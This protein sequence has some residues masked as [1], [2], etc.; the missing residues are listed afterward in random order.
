[1]VGAH[2]K[3]GTQSLCPLS[4]PPF[5]WL[6]WV[7]WPP[8]LFSQSSV[9]KEVVWEIGGWAGQPAGQQGCVGRSSVGALDL[10][11]QEPLLQAWVDLPSSDETDPDLFI[12]IPLGTFGCG[13][14]P[15]PSV[16]LHPSSLVTWGVPCPLRPHRLT[17]LEWP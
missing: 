14:H 1:M 13:L 10:R 17:E 11:T 7:L 3:K 15:G 12:P 4:W 8:L 16:R 5:L 9:L 6:S 2:S